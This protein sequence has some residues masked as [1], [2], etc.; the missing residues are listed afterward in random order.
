MEERR[1]R[2]RKQ[3]IEKETAEDYG[4]ME[5]RIKKKEEADDRERRVQNVM[6]IWRR[7]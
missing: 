5:E 2:R 7:E 3:R 1:K 4:D 6:E